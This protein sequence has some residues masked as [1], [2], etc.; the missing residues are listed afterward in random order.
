MQFDAIQRTIQN[1]SI[2]FREELSTIFEN[3]EQSSLSQNSLEAA[4]KGKIDS[5]ASYLINYIK[6]KKREQVTSDGSEIFP[7]QEEQQKFQ[8]DV[9]N[10]QIKRREYVLM[11]QRESFYKQ[12]N[13]LKLQL[14]QKGRMGEAFIPQEVEFYDPKNLDAIFAKENEKDEEQLR[15]RITTQVT[16]KFANFHQEEMRKIEN[17]IQKMKEE[18]QQQIEQKEQEM[19]QREERLNQYIAMIEEEKKKN[20][21]A[22]KQEIEDLRMTSSN[23]LQETIEKFQREKKDTLILS[24]Q[25][26]RQKLEE[27]DKTYAQQ[28]FQLE[29]QIQDLGENNAQG[30]NR[31]QR[32]DEKISELKRELKEQ[33]QEKKKTLDENEKLHQVIQD[34]TLQISTLELQLLDA[35]YKLE[36]HQSEQKS[37]IS[38]KG[39]Q[40]GISVVKKEQDWHQRE[41]ELLKK[42][43][44]LEE[45][46]KKQIEKDNIF[47]TQFGNVMYSDPSSSSFI[48]YQSNSQSSNLQLKP[49]DVKKAE[50]KVQL[51]ELE[52][53]IEKDKE[54]KKQQINT[55]WAL[56]K[57]ELIHKSK[58]KLDPLEIQNVNENP[59]SP[60]SAQI[61]RQI[62][63]NPIRLHQYQAQIRRVI[64]IQTSHHILNLHKHVKHPNL[65]LHFKISKINLPF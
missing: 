41:Q 52:Q 65:L 45:R 50:Q 46:E 60:S 47:V 9:L 11:K 7:Q 22:S 26:H 48:N 40:K 2:R 15:K 19:Q 33:Q 4:A 14:E 13:A 23:Q 29:K 63:L 64:S 51:S 28:I 59:K 58:I 35:R 36:E 43:S 27:M 37:D 30:D 12:L 24:A 62:K 34:K 16:L 1:G 57:S 56:F 8:T 31:V 49:L 39:S 20:E 55:N 10:E 21:E 5:F 17:R 54:L 42:I 18:N 61:D 32:L 3:A 6:D 38:T 25:D 44:Y 53:A